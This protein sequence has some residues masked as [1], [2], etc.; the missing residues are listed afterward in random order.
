MPRKL[1]KNFFKQKGRILNP[2]GEIIPCNTAV[3][4]EAISTLST[5][6]PTKKDIVLQKI[7]TA[8]DKIKIATSKQFLLA[9]SKWAGA[10]LAITIF[11][12]TFIFNI[13]LYKYSPTVPDKYSL[14]SSIPLTLDSVSQELDYS[15]SRSIRIDR[16]FEVF[17]CPMTGLGETIVK[18]A[19]DNDIPYWVVAAIAFQESSCGKNTPVIDGVKTKNAWGW[20]TYGES[21]YEFDSY[22]QGIQIVSKYL[23]KK[24]YSRGVTDLCEI[25]RTYTPP[26]NG[27]WCKGVQYFGDFIQS[28]KSP[29]SS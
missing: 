26:S 21:V 27:S 5:V 19:D 14:F 23:S 7:S 22:E 4:R 6:K 20:A 10:I 9:N 28:Y 16:V 24:F 29:T 3:P 2:L 17:N 25:M 11:L 12:A 1:S 8:H 15:D 18:Q 13:P